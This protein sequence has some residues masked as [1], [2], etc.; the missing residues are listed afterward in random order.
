MTSEGKDKDDCTLR[1][2]SACQT[3]KTGVGGIPWT[4]CRPLLCKEIVV[5]KLFLTHIATSERTTHVQEA[6]RNV[7]KASWASV[8][9]TSEF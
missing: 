1:V 5:D 2:V 9:R 3:R 6:P 8:P 4:M 7:E